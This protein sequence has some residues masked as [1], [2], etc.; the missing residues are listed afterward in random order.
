MRK[1]E[2]WASGKQNWI[3][4]LAEIAWCGKICHQMCLRTIEI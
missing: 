1:F 2:R 4:P 3:M